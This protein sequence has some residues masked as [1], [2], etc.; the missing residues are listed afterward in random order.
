MIVYDE[1]W[2]GVSEP[3]TPRVVAEDEAVGEEPAARRGRT[4]PK[5]PV[6]TLRL[7]VCLLLGL[8]AFGWKS[9]GGEPYEQA[10]A[11]YTAALNDAAIAEDARGFDF[12]ALSGAT[13]DEV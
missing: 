9:I 6:L 3:E 13:D 2:Q 1:G 12:G 5:Q 10:R 4:F 11:W 7:V 8:A